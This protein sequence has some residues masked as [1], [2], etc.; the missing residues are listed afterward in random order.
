MGVELLILGTFLT[1]WSRWRRKPL[2][3]NKKYIYIYYYKKIFPLIKRLEHFKIFT[4]Y[5]IEKK[6]FDIKNW[7]ILR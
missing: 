1:A 5:I 3:L 7:R 4:V 2:L 6:F